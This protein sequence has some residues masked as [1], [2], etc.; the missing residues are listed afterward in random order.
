M[1]SSMSS[2][3]TSPAVDESSTQEASWTDK[4]GVGWRHISH[5]EWVSQKWQFY[6]EHV[7]VA[8]KL[9]FNVLNVA[10]KSG[11]IMLVLDGWF[12]AHT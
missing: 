3:S 4:N 10:N 2:S 12:M 7:Q 11:F 6:L 9:Y 8:V 5:L 1:L